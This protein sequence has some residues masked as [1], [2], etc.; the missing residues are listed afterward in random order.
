[1]ATQV[2]TWMTVHKMKMDHNREKHGTCKEAIPIFCFNLFLYDLEYCFKFEMLYTTKQIV[3]SQTY[4]LCIFI[5]INVYWKLEGTILWKIFYTAM[6]TKVKEGEILPE[7]TWLW[8]WDYFQPRW[9]ATKTLTMY[10]L[11]KKN[12]CSRLVCFSQGCKFWKWSKS[13]RFI[14]LVRG[15]GQ[16]QATASSTTYY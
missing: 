9:V 7:K 6:G 3:I 10:Y 5:T 4:Q 1:M 2:I 15:A 11:L 14:E 8:V 12:Q 13:D 16:E